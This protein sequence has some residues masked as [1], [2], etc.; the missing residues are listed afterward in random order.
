[1]RLAL[2]P[3]LVLVLAAAG[4]AGPQPPGE[5]GPVVSTSWLAQHV[6]DPDLV[7]LHVGDKTQY[8][9]AHIPG[10]HFVAVS[11]V[12]RSDADKGGLRLEMLPADVLREKLAAL[13]ISDQS[14]IV[15]YYGQDWVSPAT[16]ILFTL[17]YAGLGDRSFLLD[18]GQAAWVRA[19]HEVTAEVPAVVSGNLAS[20]KPRPLVVDRAQVRESLG[21]PGFAVIDARA[22]G[23][24]SGKQTGGGGDAPHRSGHIAGALSVPFS[25]LVDDAL[26]L[27]SKDELADIFAKAGVKPGDTVIGYCHIGQQA[28]ASL[29]A[30]RRLG[31]RV[32]LYD[33]SFEEWTKYADDPV[34][35]PASTGKP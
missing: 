4:N 13:G 8:D 34:D 27:R 7:L 29:F 5:D 14:K 22:P 10:A 9:A 33:G 12:S 28:T 15:V 2:V 21:Q 26:M 19:G 11:E 23:F 1:M 16:R 25:E 35:N 24:Y 18:G 6:A 31:H 3:T 20:L 17:D 30:A 32:L